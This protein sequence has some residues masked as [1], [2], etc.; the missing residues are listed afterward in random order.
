MVDTGIINLDSG[1]VVEKRGHDRSRGSKNKAKVATMDT[2]S[3]AL[4]KRRLG[5]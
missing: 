4:A 2:S 3:F 1:V 5:R